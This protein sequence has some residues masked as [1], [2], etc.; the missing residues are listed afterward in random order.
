VVGNPNLAPGAQ[1]W[2]GTDTN[3][4]DVY[5]R[6]I[7]ATS[8]NVAIGACVAGLTTALGILIGLT[9]GMNE[10]RRGL[11]GSLSRALTRV[12]DLADA[13]PV[14]LV[15]IVALSLFG[16]RVTTLVVALTVILVPL[17][18]R[19]VRTETLRVRSEAFLDAARL[20][21]QS[22]VELTVRHVLPNASWPALG[23]A[24]VVFGYSCILTA[25]L[26][27]LGVGLRPPTAEWGSMISAGVPG[28]TTGQWW[29]SGFPA[30]ALA[31]SVVCVAHA[32]R[33]IFGRFR[34]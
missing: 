10:S 14:I 34:S 17:Q 4:M 16:A 31:L 15:G 30:V 11:V 12:I 32:S 28:A 22:E 19:V 2:F 13:I 6:T 1:F 21:G 9:V 26:G 25:S 23:N 33:A 27:F 8:L 7:A 24:S 18:A 3:G 5:S 29:A 20:A